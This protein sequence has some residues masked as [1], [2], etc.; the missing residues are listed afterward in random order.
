M[1]AITRIRESGGGAVTVTDD[2]IVGAIASLARTTGVFAEPA[3][4]AALAGLVRALEESTIDRDERVVLLVT[5]SGL[6]D[7]PA[8]ARS[9]E[10]PDPVAP[11]LEA[12]EELLRS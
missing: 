8:A 5:G 4:A 7:V 12:V 11:E 10:L 9:V 3:G 6:K 1:L 2:E